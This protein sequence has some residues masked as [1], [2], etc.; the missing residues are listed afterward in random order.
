MTSL[1]KE[2]EKI[3]DDFFRQS[4]KE[5]QKKLKKLQRQEMENRIKF[6]SNPK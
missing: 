4:E 5:E 3:I 1:E 6:E 2:I